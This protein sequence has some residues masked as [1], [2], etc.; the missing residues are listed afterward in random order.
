[1]KTKSSKAGLPGMRYLLAGAAVATMLAVSAVSASAAPIDLQGFG[2]QVSV[3][4]SNYESFSATQTLTAGGVPV[5]APAIG[6]DN[7]GIF[8]V[9]SVG[10]VGS[11]TNFLNGSP[12]TYVGV[13]NDI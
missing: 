12:Y 5:T 3:K 10:P 7:Y 9:N 8:V 1:M 4:F 11:N 13:F 2:G 6:S